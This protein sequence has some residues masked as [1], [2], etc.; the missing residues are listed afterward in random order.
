MLKPLSLLLA[1]D[2][3]AELLDLQKRYEEDKKKVAKLRDQ[4]KFRP[5]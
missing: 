1:L 4:R 5:Y 2:V 3:C